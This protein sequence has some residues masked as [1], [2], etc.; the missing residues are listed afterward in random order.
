MRAV[1][2]PVSMAVSAVL[3]FAPVPLWAATIQVD[4]AM[5]LAGLPIGAANLT[6]AIDD[7]RYSLKLEG[8]LTGLVGALSG[9]SRGAATA[10]GALSGGRPVA[11]GF[12]ATA[13]SSSSERILQI[14][15]SSGNVT[16][17]QIDPPFEERPDRVPLGEADKRGV[18]DPLSGLVAVAANR[19]APLDPANCN[20]TIPV[21]EGTQR[22]NVVLSFAETRPVKKPGYVGNV[23]VCNARY[24]PI[25]G[26]RPGRPAVQFMVENRDMSV[27]LAPVEGARVLVPLR[28]A[29]RTMIGTSVIEA[30]SWRVEKSAEAKP[31]R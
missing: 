20:R 29:V 31:A 27:W 17:V 14:G 10:N 4:Y 30:Q 21:F 22:F 19:A 11:A 13:R 1:L 2:R 28:I 5:T 16:K 12:A 25:A 8:H 9:G 15:L 23:L 3:I 26:H 7:E 6:G 18:L 24:V